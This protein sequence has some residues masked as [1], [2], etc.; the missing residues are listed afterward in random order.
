MGCLSW[1]HFGE[2]LLWCTRVWCNGIALSVQ[3]FCP[4]R[5]FR[6]GMHDLR[7]WPKIEAD[8]EESPSST[9]GKA[10]G[11][12]D[13]MGRLSK[14]GIV[15]YFSFWK[16]H[17]TLVVISGTTDLVPYHLKWSHHNS[18]GD[19]VSLDETY[20]NPFF[21]S[22]T[23]IWQRWEV[24]RIGIPVLATRGYTLFHKKKKKKCWFGCCHCIIKT[25][26]MHK[27]ILNSL[28]V[29]YKYVFYWVEKKKMRQI[30]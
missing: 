13:H 4:C 21:R 8:G 1:E 9:P 24:T 7:V 12:D 29:L 30:L 5:T 10:L 22:V 16:G 23:V 18:S 25:I 6:Q 27:A 17:V 11:R 26:N 3:W 28:P 19:R 20:K 14:V 15:G 2:K